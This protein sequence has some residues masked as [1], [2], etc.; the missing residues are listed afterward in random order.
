[1][2]RSLAAPAFPLCGGLAGLSGPRAGASNFRELPCR[3]RLGRELDQAIISRQ[4][5]KGDVCMEKQKMVRLKWSGFI[6]QDYRPC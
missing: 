5:R 6:V 2:Q 3:R 4:P 1:M